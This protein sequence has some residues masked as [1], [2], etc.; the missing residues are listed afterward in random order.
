MHESDVVPLNM[1]VPEDPGAEFDIPID[2]DVV[3]HR[4]S[5]HL[6]GRRVAMAGVVQV[7]FLRYTPCGGVFQCPETWPVEYPDCP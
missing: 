4:L 7:G 3:I 5:G 2:A 1:P 6:A